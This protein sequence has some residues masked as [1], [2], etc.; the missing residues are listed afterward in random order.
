MICI[1]D[2]NGS[3]ALYIS[4][5]RKTWI[6]FLSFF[7]ILWSHPIKKSI[8]M[9][10][11]L[12]NMPKPYILIWYTRIFVCL[13]FFFF[14]LWWVFQNEKRA[15]LEGSSFSMSST[16]SNVSVHSRKLSGKSFCVV[17]VGFYNGNE[18]LLIWTHRQLDICAYVYTQ[19]NR[20]NKSLSYFKGS[21]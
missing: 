19:G 8:S 9:V 6:T 13:S 20:R 4:V 10:S 12:Q 21:S 2:E 3:E 14:L 1:H 16:V 18:Q 5:L 7:L 17:C 11:Y 15:G